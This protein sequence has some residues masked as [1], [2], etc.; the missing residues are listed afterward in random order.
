MMKLAQAVWGVLSK[1]ILF[2]FNLLLKPFGK[3]MTPEQ[4]TSLLQFCKFAIIGVSNTIVSMCI[5]FCILFMC[6]KFGWFVANEE[7]QAHLGNTIAFYLSVIWSFYWNSKFVF[8]AG[9]ESEKRVWWKTLVRTYLAYSITGLGISNLISDLCIKSWGISKYIAVLINLVIAVPI[10]FI[11]N[12]F[13]AYNKKEDKN[14]S[15]SPAKVNKLGMVGALVLFISIL[16]PFMS[17]TLPASTGNV[18]LIEL[19]IVIP[20]VTLAIN[21]AVLFLIS[22]AGDNNRTGMGI[23]AGILL[24]FNTLVILMTDAFAKLLSKEALYRNLSDASFKISA[25]YI[26]LF[27]AIVLILGGVVVG[28][29]KARKEN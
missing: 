21:F 23:V 19:G 13:W 18:T 3:K 26:V 22:F 24:V 8:K 27:V 12:K 2:C 28:A 29:S 4:E 6:G 25:G 7:Y 1:I 16:L 10:N 14:T 5:N 11:L 9:D 17:Y 20:Y 15:K